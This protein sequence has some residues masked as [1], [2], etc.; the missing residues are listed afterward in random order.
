MAIATLIR[1]SITKLT[2]LMASAVNRFRTWLSEQRNFFFSRYTKD[3][4]ETQEPERSLVELP[5]EL[6]QKLVDAVKSI[7]SNPADKKAIAS[8]LDK[9]FNLWRSSNEI[10]LKHKFIS[11]I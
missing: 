10:G 1:E 5:P 9:S 8:T 4:K 7:P 6:S 2:N 11:R 3:V